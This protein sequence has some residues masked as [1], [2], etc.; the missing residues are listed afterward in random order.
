M[1]SWHETTLRGLCRLAFGL[2]VA[3]PTCAVLLAVVWCRSSLSVEYYRRAIADQLAL[4][5]RLERVS[6]PR[7]NVTLLTGLTLADPETARPLAQFGDLEW[8]TVGLKSSVTCR[9]AELL[10]SSR[11]DLLAELVARRLRL[12]AGAKTVVEIQAEQLTLQLSADTAPQTLTKVHGQLQGAP[13]KPPAQGAKSEPQGTVEFHLAGQEKGAP[14]RISFYRAVSQARATISMQIDTGPTPLP[15]RLIELCC[16]GWET[17]GLDSTFRG[18]LWWQQR[19]DGLAGEARGLVAGV[20]LDKLISTRSEHQLSGVA[21]VQLDGV[22]FQHGRLLDA[23]GSIHAGPGLVGRSL[24]A[25]AVR[26]LR[27]T[28]NNPAAPR[29]DLAPYNEMAFRFAIDERGLRIRGLCSGSLGAVFVG[30][31]G[32]MLGEPTGPLGEPIGPQSLLGVVRL[33]ATVGDAVP[34]DPAAQSLLSVLPV[35]VA[36]STGLDAPAQADRAKEHKNPYR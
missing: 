8:R 18:E 35:P 21:E 7:P 11:L 10:D 29:E 17:W 26:Q 9:Q 23:T 5:V 36:Q 27:A 4:D 16:P 13:S 28:G 33:L 1:F 3:A 22:R 19:A 20:D 6:F 25:A 24:L 15:S 12:F 14:A 31:N 34:A 30:R 32:P 2:L